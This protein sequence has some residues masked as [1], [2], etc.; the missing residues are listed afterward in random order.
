MGKLG[1][2]QISVSFLNMLVILTFSQFTLTHLHFEHSNIQ[3][4]KHSCIP[5]FMHYSIK[6]VTCSSTVIRGLV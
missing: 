5:A 6:K 3:T 4:F 2:V 1:S